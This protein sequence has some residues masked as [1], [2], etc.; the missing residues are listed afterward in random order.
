MKLAAAAARS[1]GRAA[2]QQ[3]WLL[4]V[5]SV[6]CSGTVTIRGMA[7]VA[8]AAAGVAV[9]EVGVCRMWR[10][11]HTDLRPAEAGHLAAVLPAHADALMLR[12]HWGLSNGVYLL[13]APS[14]DALAALTTAMAVRVAAAARALATDPAA[15]AAA[16]VPAAI[17][18]VLGSDAGREALRDG[19]PIMGRF[20][21]VL[22]GYDVEAGTFVPR[23]LEYNGDTAGTLVESTTLQ[24]A[25]EEV[26]VPAL[27]ADGRLPAAPLA[28]ATS[29]GG[30]LRA[31]LTAA[32]GARLGAA[33][34]VYVAHHYG[35]RYLVDTGRALADVLQAAGIRDV[36]RCVY[37]DMPPLEDAAAPVLKLYRWSRI[38]LPESPFPPVAAWV[39]AHGLRG[40]WEPLLAYLLQHKGLLTFFPRHPNCL[41]TV[42]V[43]DVD[44]SA[45]PPASMS[46]AAATLP[47]ATTAGVFYKPFTGINATGVAHLPAAAV[48]ERSCGAG[49]AGDGAGLPAGI[50]Q[51]VEPVVGVP[52]HGAVRAPPAYPHAAFGGHVVHP[53]LSTWVVNGVF[54]GVVVRESVT[55]ITIDEWVMPV[56][57]QPAGAPRPGSPP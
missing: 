24:T 37:P 14:Y 48:V 17:R 54:A 18:A 38:L 25:W 27:V 39:A 35:E 50:L 12:N 57:R 4:R 28:G 51:Q 36:R 43:G 41:T 21:W 47:A 34:R 31:A 26:V 22:G 9:P 16:G 10:L 44:G 49:A 3:T 19:E 56:L 5:S 52:A 1:V 30:M 13:D 7:G 40:V 45:V 15:Q 11:P 55:P 33:P 20:D 8:A 46:A 6:R 29:T 42:A 23:L 32:Y 53:I 2:T